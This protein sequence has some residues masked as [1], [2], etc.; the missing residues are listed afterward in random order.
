MDPI[1][2]PDPQCPRCRSVTSVVDAPATYH[3]WW[4]Q[5]CDLL[6]STSASYAVTDQQW[7]ADAYRQWRDH[8]ADPP[9]ET[10]TA[11]ALADRAARIARRRE[12]SR[13]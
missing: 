3:Q 6:F 7:A 1:E 2:L 13:A 9:P 11:R 4:C 10:E 12:E 8:P 5:R